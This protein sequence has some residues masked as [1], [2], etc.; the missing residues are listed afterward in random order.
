[1]E[2]LAPCSLG[3]LFSLI[4]VSLDGQDNVENDLIH[5]GSE[6]AAL[7]FLNQRSVLSSTELMTAIHKKGSKNGPECK[8][9]SFFIPE[10]FLTDFT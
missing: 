2:L 1:M 4:Q 9:C 7:G 8:L 6:L 5:E 10:S 3:R